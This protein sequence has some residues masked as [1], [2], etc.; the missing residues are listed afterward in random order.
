MHD[1][2][3]VDRRGS[4]GA[5]ITVGSDFDGGLTWARRAYP[6]LIYYHQAERGGHFAAWEY[7]E[8]FATELRAAFKTLR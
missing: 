8:D 7:P 1:E 3:N 5:M 4:I 6:K 2:T